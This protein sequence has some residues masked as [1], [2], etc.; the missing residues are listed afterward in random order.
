MHHTS[1]HASGTS[2]NRAGD[3]VLFDEKIE[4]DRGHSQVT[5]K[6]ELGGEGAIRVVFEG[7]NA[8]TVIFQYADPADALVI[9][10]A[11]IRAA[12][13][14]IAAQETEAG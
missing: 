13:T 6:V 12:E 7:R 1:V 11:L 10:R 8:P 9:G 14:A 4:T 2:E 5:I 3:A